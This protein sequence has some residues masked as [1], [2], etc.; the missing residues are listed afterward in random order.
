MT[1]I[2][3]LRQLADQQQF[4]L[5][6]GNARACWLETADPAALPLLALA[7]ANLGQR[8]GAEDALAQ[9]EPLRESL[10]LDARVDLA[11]AHILT[12]RLPSAEDLLAAALAEQPE[13]ALALARLAFCHMHAGRL[14][15]ARALYRHATQG[16]PHR[17]PVW[18]ALARLDLQAD[19]LSAAQA[20]LDAAQVQL[21]AQRDLLP[22]AVANSFSAQLNSLQLEIWLH[23]AGTAQ[24]EAWLEAQRSAL[25]EDDWVAYASGYASALAGCDRHAE[26]DTT[27]REALKQHPDNFA[28]LS[29]LAELAQVQGRS[30]QAVQVLRRALALAKR[31]GEPVPR[32]IGLHTRIAE[33]CLRGLDQ[34]A[35]HAAEE[36]MA[37]TDGLAASD[38]LPEPQLRALR[39]Q[40]KNA[41]AQ[42][43]SEEQHFEAAEALYNEVL[44]DNPWFL[45]AL[46]GLG[47]QQMLRGRIDE[48]IALFERVQQINPARGAS[49]LINARQIPDDPQT[50]ERMQQLAH[51]P[52]LEGSSR[53]GLLFQL[54][55]AWEKK[56]DYERAFALAT[57]ANAASRLHL[58][59]DPQEHRQRCAR[60]RHAFGPALLAHRAD[61]GYRGED[62]SLPVF[63]LGMPRSG[64]TLV[65]Q[66]IAGHS[67]VFGAGELGVIPSRI[68]GL[69][70]WERHVGSGRSYPDCI[71]DLNPYATHGIAQGVITELKA[72][73]AQSK[74]E[75]RFVVDKL[76]H[77]FENIGLIKFLFPKA[78]IISVRRDPRDIAMSNYFTDY[79]AKHGGMGFA[80]DLDWIGEQLADHNLLMHH[81]QQ[82]FPGEILEVKYEDVVEDTEAMARQ[83]LDYI[84]VPWEPQV[85]N[86]SELDRPVKTASVWQVR[87][88]IYKTSK[89]KWEHYKAHLAPLIAGTNRKIEWT[90]IEMQ[91]LPTP[92]LLTDAVALY[93][94]GQ[95]DEA[96]YEFKKLLHHFPEHAAAN[97]MVGLIYV[98]KGHLPDGIALM[99]QALAKCPWKRPWRQDLIKACELAGETDKAEALMRPLPGDAAA[100]A[101][102]E[103]AGEGAD[104]AAG[105]A[106]VH[107][108]AM[109]SAPFTS[110]S[111]RVQ[112]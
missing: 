47:H 90:P 11:A 60:I 98:H 32:L 44:T 14:P 102:A 82:L 34:Q 25:P 15:E 58:H 24:A 45:P 8:A 41:L 21:T 33:A 17:L 110:S 4:E 42:V 83:M 109:S 48:A 72:L 85:L 103:D 30:L 94:D 2:E 100:E 107:A 9:L 73:A 6:A 69:N 38:E 46:Q 27:L 36:A 37:L 64:T 87:Q 65:E 89:A 62:E 5:L 106:A 84:G 43:E 7:C 51:Q 68:Q 1:V 71:D 59:Y 28:L 20:A 49:A 99:E 104:T 97:F 92:G 108:P 81:W 31:Q 22:A 88:P 35:R 101:D 53:S 56:K 57:E 67:Q 78:K 111:A 66:I 55:S 105:A 93:K 86:F 70:R 61:C 39:W 96:E 77:N 29:Q 16:A 112:P 95:L 13:H 3:L 10:D 54:A 50:L 91:S 63:V 18:A 75:A 23:G 80:Y 26:A 12:G 74:P 52:S 40:A 19:D 79:A 76:P